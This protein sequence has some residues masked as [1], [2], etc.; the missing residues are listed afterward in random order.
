MKSKRAARAN[1][2]PRAK[3]R[4]ITS[5][6]IECIA[7]SDKRSRNILFRILLDS[8]APAKKDALWWAQ[9]IV[10][11]LVDFGNPI[12]RAAYFA[13][14]HAVRYLL[15]R[16][17]ALAS[18]I[19]ERSPTRIEE[20]TGAPY[21]R[22]RMLFTDGILLHAAAASAGAVHADGRPVS[23]DLRPLAEGVAEE[24]G[25]MYPTLRAR[26]RESARVDAIQAA[27]ASAAAS[28]RRTPWVLI[29]KAWDGVEA[30]SIDPTQWRQRY[31]EHKA[32][33]R[34]ERG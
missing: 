5:E 27:I 32:A 23:T 10:G 14:D 2:T 15:T 31:R 12:D 30:H 20:E 26:M 9:A 11:R 29:A 22:A 4:T 34:T 13:I 7:A 6:D 19:R 18:E 8:G 1:R 16:D 33:T 28:P 25:E 17:P 3:S 21:A 24:V